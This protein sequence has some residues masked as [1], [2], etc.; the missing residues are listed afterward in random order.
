MYS[1]SL[2][3][4]S[5][6]REPL[7]SPPP[8]FTLTISTLERI[9]LLV[10]HTLDLQHATRKFPRHL[11][12]SCHP[13]H[14][15]LYFYQRTLCTPPRLFSPSHERC[16][17]L[18]PPSAL[19][20]ACFGSC[21]EGVSRAIRRGCDVAHIRLKFRL[22]ARQVRYVTSALSTRGPVVHPVIIER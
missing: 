9:Q 10:R 3:V 21:F 16:S 8:L 7:S 11:R 18:H 15:S 17:S 1:G 2:R 4:A 6:N 5:P 19:F 12:Q 13:R 20:R 22:S 14:S